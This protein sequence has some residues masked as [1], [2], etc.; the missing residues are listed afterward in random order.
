MIVYLNGK[1]LQLNPIDAIGKGGEAD[2]FDI[3]G[4]I[5]LKAFK[6]PNHPDLV[7]F[8]EDQLVAKLRLDEHQQK[9]PAFPKNLPD[10]VISPINLVTDR[11]GSRILGYT[12]RFLK[13]YEVILRYADRNFR[14]AGISNEQVVNTF[15]DLHKTVCGVHN[16][17]VVIGDF[18]DLNIM[19][20]NNEACIIDADSFQ[21]RGFLCTVFT[22][23]F[24][25]PLLCNQSDIRPSLFKTYNP[26]SDWY[27]FNIMLMQ[28]LLFVGP[29][30]GIYKPKDK[31]KRI[32]HA[33]RPLKRITVFN[34]EVKYP[35]PATHYNVLPDSLLQHFHLVF[36][37]DKRI[38]FPVDILE[39]MRWTAC[40]SCGTSHA[41]R[42][43]P[44]CVQFSPSA[45]VET[46]RGNVTCTR[47]FQTS[48]MILFATMQ[49]GRLRFLY[50]EGGEFKRENNLYSVKGSLKPTM[51]FRI[52]G[53]YTLVG[54]KDQL[55]KLASGEKP[56]KITVDS[57]GSLPLFD[58]NSQSNYWIYDG[59]LMKEDTYG[60][61]HI[62][63]VLSKQTLFW[64]GS[65]FGFGFYRAGN[66]NVGF[67]FNTSG[68]AINDSVKLPP[69]RGQLIDSTCFFADDWAWFII[70]TREK[71][72]TT[73]KCMIIKSNG[74]IKA[75][76]E[77][78][79]GD[80]SWLGTIRGKCAAGNFLLAATD[81]GIVRVEPVGGNLDVIK[82]FPDTEPFIDAG[83]HLFPGRGCLYVVSRRSIKS[84]KIS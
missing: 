21:Y 61:K 84:L 28:S 44:V 66:F 56:E 73:N 60:P 34:P 75:T 14:Q 67:V 47:D 83:C 62:G 24:V 23:K 22:E 41:R 40:T 26:E 16:A 65:K 6:Q 64:V 19:A 82:D 71:G 68:G 20:A 7:G 39:S 49:G 81:D 8:K 30:G 63:D 36:Q 5:V 46:V 1:K 74:D 15:L 33:T 38:I 80:G 2:I 55:V 35:K 50:Y 70:S 54:E 57:F 53:K 29:Y 42:V 13:G 52:C 18:N 51:R 17:G 10:R 77:A 58:S 78:T 43:C 3:G 4:G 9:L 48:G 45:V 25:D 69:I 59:R 32:N 31:K 79:D 27:A 72:R 12:M 76:A 11:H 37:E